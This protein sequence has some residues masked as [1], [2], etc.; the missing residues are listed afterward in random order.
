MKLTL[1]EVCNILQTEIN[2]CLDHPDPELNNDQQM[3]FMN[4]LRQAQ[5]LLKGGE[6]AINGAYKVLPKIGEVKCKCP[7]CNWKGTVDDCEPDI[8]GDGSLG[9]PKCSTVIEV[10]I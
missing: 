4:G 6:L 5:H 10:T 3:G 1:T 8:D 2:W 9:C 7:S